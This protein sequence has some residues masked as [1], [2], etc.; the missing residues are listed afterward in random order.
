MKLKD[1]VMMVLAAGCGFLGGVASIRIPYGTQLKVAALDSD[2]V[3]ASRIELLD[4]SDKT[5]VILGMDSRLHRDPILSFLTNDGKTVASFGV[6]ER[7]PF[8]RL[9]GRGGEIRAALDLSG[10][11]L[12]ELRMGDGT[13]G[14]RVVLGAFPE[15]IASTGKS[16]AT[17]G[18]AFRSGVLSTIALMSMSPSGP[19]HS[20][21]GYLFIKNPKHSF[22]VP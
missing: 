3:R 19:D 18:L 2:V 11:E 13:A 20:F 14:M 7:L 15:D 17:W 9:M 22:S 8:I 1:I 10:Q 21:S 5:R 16:D 4:P 6:E 12:P